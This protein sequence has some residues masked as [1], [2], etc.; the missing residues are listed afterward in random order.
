MCFL[1]MT[2]SSSYGTWRVSHCPALILIHSLYSLLHFYYHYFTHIPPIFPL[3]YQLFFPHLLSF[4]LY[5]VLQIVKL[6]FN[7]LFR[8]NLSSLHPATLHHWAGT[9]LFWHLSKPWSILPKLITTTR[10]TALQTPARSSLIQCLVL[11]HLTPPLYQLVI[12]LLF[13]RW[14]DNSHL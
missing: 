1:F 3:L 11:L 10:S 6:C 7:F 5:I 2:K 8:H 4:H 9:N 13:I 14:Q 12:L